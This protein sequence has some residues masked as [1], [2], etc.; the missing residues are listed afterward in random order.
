M[1]GQGGEDFGAACVWDDK[2]GYSVNYLLLDRVSP[3]EWMSLTFG[4]EMIVFSTV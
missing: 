2:E 4:K 3:A 1:G